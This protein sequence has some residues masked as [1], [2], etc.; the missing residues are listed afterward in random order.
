MNEIASDA[1][2]VPIPKAAKSLGI[3]VSYLYQLAGTGRLT[4]RKIGARSLVEASSMRQLV[5]AAP[6]ARIRPPARPKAA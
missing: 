5:E 4:L 1:L 3:S 2:L 6:V